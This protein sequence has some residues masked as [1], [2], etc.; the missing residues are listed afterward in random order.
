M[1]LTLFSRLKEIG[2]EFRMSVP[3]HSSSELSKG[4]WL[5]KHACLLL[6]SLL[7]TLLDLVPSWI[8]KYLRWCPTSSE[9]LEEA[10]RRLLAYVKK[11]FQSKFVTID[12]ILKCKGSHQIR[13]IEMGPTN[14]PPPGEERVPLVLVH[15][16]A[17][18]VALWLLN[19]DKL[20]ED[21]TVYSFD[22]LGFGRSSRPRLSSDSLE[23]EYQFVQSLEEW[24]AQV[25][26]DRFVL[27][28]HSMGG[29][30]AAS[31][32]LRF[33]ERVAHLVLA[34]P[35]GFPE[36][37]V[38]SPKALQLPTW[39]RA[40]STLLS[41]FNPL[42][43]LRVAGP[44]GPLLV[45]KIRADIGKKYEHIVQD[46]EAVP[47]YIYHCNAQFP[48]GE[49]A[50]K[51][52]MTQYGWARHPMVNRI[53]ELHVGVPM[54]FIYGSK[55]WV[56]KQPGIQVQQVREE[57]E[58]DVEIIEGAGHHVFAD[59]PD[60]F[61]DMVCKLCRNTDAAERIIRALTENEDDEKADEKNLASSAKLLRSKVFL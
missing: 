32:A 2:S 13:T 17:S 44:W 29:F 23:A 38:P 36:R 5:L 39:V 19:L 53:A 58:V 18:G 31:Y 35:W 43:A 55:S 9:R 26:L 40:V 1:L 45:E 3:D 37:R 33:P 49:S 41:P 12:S 20:S 10:E 14:E 6:D 56:D 11:P 47:R 15:G 61:N 54:T 42:V 30:L 28:G 27:L 7:S 52:M 8:S 48:S 59:R 50:F 21:R 57:S 16:F 60:Q 51:A 4:L 22:T 46:S 25:G 34:D 24:R